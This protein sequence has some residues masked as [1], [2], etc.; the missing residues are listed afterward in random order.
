VAESGTTRPQ[1][2][3]RNLIRSQARRKP[4]N[5]RENS[6]HVKVKVPIT[7]VRRGSGNS[8]RR[9]PDIQHQDGHTRDS[10][11]LP[12]PHG[13]RGNHVLDPFSRLPSVTLGELKVSQELLRHCESIDLTLNAPPIPSLR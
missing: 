4:K 8:A 2:T 6:H 1:G 9:D 11:R 10:R 13:T 7:A 3:V 5:S 12:D